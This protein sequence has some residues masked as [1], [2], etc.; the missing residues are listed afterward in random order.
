MSIRSLIFGVNSVTI[1][2]LIRDD[3]LLQNATDV[4]TKCNG[5]FI[6]KCDRN[7]LQNASGF[8]L[9]NATVITK[10]N[11]YYKLRQY[12]P[13]SNYTKNHGYVV[14][15]STTFQFSQSKSVLAMAKYIA[16]NSNSNFYLMDCLIYFL[17]KS[18]TVK[19]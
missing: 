1:S 7:L 19:I 8:L 18:N 16:P 5:Y 4:I 10:C 3:S 9:Q 13:S 2:Y 6:T 14:R 17:S 15:T 11:I 12:N